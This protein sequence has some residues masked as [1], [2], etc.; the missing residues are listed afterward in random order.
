MPLINLWYHNLA[1]LSVTF[2]RESDNEGARNETS[3]RCGRWK[4]RPINPLDLELNK[5]FFLFRW[6]LTA[7]LQMT[8]TDMRHGSNS[9]QNSNYVS[10]ARLHTINWCDIRGYGIALCLRFVS[11]QEQEYFS[12]QQSRDHLR[13][14]ISLLFQWVLGALSRDLSCWIMKLIMHLHLVPQLRI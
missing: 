5:G 1:E 13:G 10:V 4:W 3:A 14:P 11:R 9:A 2:E 7:Q 8:K 12:L 6:S